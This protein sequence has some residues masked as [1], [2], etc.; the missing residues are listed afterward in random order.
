MARGSCLRPCRHI[1]SL[2]PALWLETGVRCIRENPESGS[3]LHLVRFRRPLRDPR[4]LDWMAHYRTGV[5]DARPH[6]TLVHE[7]RG[8]IVPRPRS[9]VRPGWHRRRYHDRQRRQSTATALPRS[10][11]SAS[12]NSR[13][14]I[15]SLERGVSTFAVQGQA[16]ALDLRIHGRRR[17]N[18]ARGARRK[19]GTMKVRGALYVGKAA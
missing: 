8:V 9:R 4:F 6:H 3:R 2:R 14:A 7:S 5:P 15:S 10:R 13:R 18:D 11:S 12:S 19:V 1:E 17:Q 16:R